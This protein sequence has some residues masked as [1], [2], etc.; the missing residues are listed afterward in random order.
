[1]S[2]DPREPGSSTGT[3][4]TQDQYGYSGF[5]QPARLVIRDDQAWATA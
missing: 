4:T 1:V 2:L 3:S 5:D